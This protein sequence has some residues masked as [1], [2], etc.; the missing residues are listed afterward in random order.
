MTDDEDATPPSGEDITL[1]PEDLPPQ[2]AAQI[3]EII[4][5]MHLPMLVDHA[6][7]LERAR[8]SGWDAKRLQKY[9]P[10]LPEWARQDLLDHKVVIDARGF[11]HQLH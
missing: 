4:G 11:L 1:G 6:F 2:L 5:Q 8:A 7:L 10:M 9:Y 3:G